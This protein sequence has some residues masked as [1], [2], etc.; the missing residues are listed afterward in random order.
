MNEIALYAVIVSVR[1][2]A[3]YILFRDGMLLSFLRVR[4]AN[5]IEDLDGCSTK[6]DHIRH[7]KFCRYIQKPLWDCLPCMGSLWT[8]IWMI[9]DGDIISFNQVVTVVFLVVGLNTLI[10]F[11]FFK[12]EE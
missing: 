4:F 8:L 12:D 3:V 5:W 7:L 11:S 10:S 2:V 9:W 1:I 6:E